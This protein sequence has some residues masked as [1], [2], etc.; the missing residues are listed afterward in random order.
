[1][2]SYA[3]LAALALMTAC[4]PARD[5]AATSRDALAPSGGDDADA[6]FLLHSPIVEDDGGDGIWDAGEGLT[7]HFSFTNQ[8]EDHW[9]Y[10]GVLGA[11]DV[12]EVTVLNAES[13]WWY[14]IEAGGTYEAQLR[15]QPSADLGSGT[16]V[17]LMAS[18]S[19]LNCEGMDEANPEMGE[20]CPDPNTL[21]VP[22]RLGAELPE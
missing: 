15:F 9:Y 10:P 22:V 19:A 18:A 2:K 13:N 21:M 5:N 12:T 7:L 3:L 17:N 4:A 6:W 20:Y 8:R 16:V 1:M 14:G 11:T